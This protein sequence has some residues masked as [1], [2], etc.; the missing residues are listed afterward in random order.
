MHYG[1]V[2]VQEV[3]ERE[4]RGEREG[5]RQKRYVSDRRP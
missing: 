2:Y 3:L 4:V 5:S 1:V